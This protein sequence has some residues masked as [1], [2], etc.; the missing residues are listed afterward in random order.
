MP[1]T[2]RDLKKLAYKPLKAA[3]NRI[4]LVK[5]YKAMASL[6]PGRTFVEQTACPNRLSP[7]RKT[8]S[9]APRT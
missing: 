5:I 2:G 9:S 6:D 4:D 7:I 1:I 3:V 8:L